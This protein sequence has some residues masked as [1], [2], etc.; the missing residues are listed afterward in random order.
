MTSYDLQI[1]FKVF[2]VLCILKFCLKITAYHWCCYPYWVW[3]PSIAFSL[4]S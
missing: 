3:W 1:T 4:F 2:V